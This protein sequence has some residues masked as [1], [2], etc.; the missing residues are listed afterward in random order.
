MAT[1]RQRAPK[2]AEQVTTEMIKAV[3]RQTRSLENRSAGEDPWVMASMFDLAAEMETAAVRA[4][5][6]LRARGYTWNDIAVSMSEN[7]P[8]VSGQTLIKR[9]AKRV[10]EINTW[11]TAGYIK[12]GNEVVVTGL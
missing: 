3:S 11:K 2:T 1:S 5:A 12:D 7:G 9:Y 10:T 8:R 4:M 6:E